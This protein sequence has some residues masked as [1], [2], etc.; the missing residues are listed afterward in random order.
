MYSLVF[1]FIIKSPVASRYRDLS[2]CISQNYTTRRQFYEILLPA[3]TVSPKPPEPYLWTVEKRVQ[4]PRFLYT[5]RLEKI[6][7]I[8]SRMSSLYIELHWQN[9]WGE[10]WERSFF[11]SPSYSIK[12]SWQQQQQGMCTR[13]S[14]W[15]CRET[16]YHLHKLRFKIK[17]CC[18]CCCCFLQ[19][20][21]S[22]ERR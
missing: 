21:K 10:N 8:P 4:T 3:F 9:N 16:F 11:F 17:H 5:K 19:R 7:K 12:F 20:A 13:S 18:C 6:N 22:R 2:M 14:E 1:T 15:A